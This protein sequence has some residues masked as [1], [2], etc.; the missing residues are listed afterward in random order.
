MTNI[1]VEGIQGM[2]KSTLINGISKLLP[3]LHVCREG[4]YSPGGSGLVCM[5][6]GGGL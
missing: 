5:D 1:F 4:D 6:V 3:K 2:G